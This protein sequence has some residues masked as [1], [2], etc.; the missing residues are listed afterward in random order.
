[1]KQRSNTRDLIFNVPDLIHRLSRYVTLEPGDVIST[2]TPSGI[3]PIGPGDVM[4]AE[5]EKIGVLRNPV[6]AGE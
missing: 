6:V 4:E 3:S 1:V 5:I 2:G